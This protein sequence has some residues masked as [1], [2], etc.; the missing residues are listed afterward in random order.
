MSGVYEVS[1]DNRLFDATF[2]TRT[3]VRKEASPLAHVRPDAPPFLIVYADNDLPFCGKQYSET[4]CQ[5][6]CSNKCEAR[7]FEAHDRNHFTLLLMA[8]VEDDPVSQ[9]VLD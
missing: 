2:G 7:A 6:L 3:T 9:A 8:A 5:A 4:F 1:D